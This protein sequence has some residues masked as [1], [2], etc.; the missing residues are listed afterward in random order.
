MVQYNGFNSCH[1]CLNPGE[2]FSAGRGYSHVYKHKVYDSRTDENVKNSATQA[3]NDGNVVLGI[4]GPSM[5]SYLKMYS[6]VNGTC[7]DPMHQVFLGVMK[8]LM[9]M[10]FSFKHKKETFSAWMKNGLFDRRLSTLKPPH[11]VNRTPRPLSDLKHYKASEFC[12]ML[13]M[14]I[15]MLYGILSPEQFE[16]VMFFSHGIF[17]E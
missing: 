11:T 8:Q 16:H 13:V 14:Y 12:S 7:V 17:V 2:T 9:S 10:W 1:K 6:F 15:P 4:K 5:F 3:A